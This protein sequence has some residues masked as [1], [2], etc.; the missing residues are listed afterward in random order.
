[1]DENWKFFK[2]VILDSIF[3]SNSVIKRLLLS[4]MFASICYYNS[5]FVTLCS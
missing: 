4:I 3:T 5:V 2:E 1:M